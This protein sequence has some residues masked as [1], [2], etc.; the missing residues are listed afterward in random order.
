MMLEL[1]EFVERVPFVGLT[2]ETCPADLWMVVSVEAEQ[3]CALPA[4][5]TDVVVD[6]P[7]I[8][9]TATT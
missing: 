8:V 5:A 1:A 2:D 7:V 6:S 4:G 3:A 9:S